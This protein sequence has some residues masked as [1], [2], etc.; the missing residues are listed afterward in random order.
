MI[1]SENNEVALRRLQEHNEKC[2]HL[3]KDGCILHHCWGNWKNIQEVIP[4]RDRR[5]VMNHAQKYEKTHPEGKERLQR[6]HGHQLLLP[7]RTKKGLASCLVKGHDS[8]FDVGQ[9]DHQP[10]R[11]HVKTR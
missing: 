9:F 1:E 6:E 4:I 10:P 2:Y 11:N 3:F 8:N 5:Q 7:P